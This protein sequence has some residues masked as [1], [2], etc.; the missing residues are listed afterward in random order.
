VALFIPK[1]HVPYYSNQQIR[2]PHNIHDAVV[3]PGAY[4]RTALITLFGYE[5]AHAALGNSLVVQEQ[6]KK[7]KKEYF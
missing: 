2:N 3:E 1:Q 5:F 6:R 4:T 7:R